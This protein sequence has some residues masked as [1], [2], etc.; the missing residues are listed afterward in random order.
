MPPLIYRFRFALVSAV[1]LALFV[2]G[3]VSGSAGSPLLLGRQNSAGTATTSLNTN[4]SSSAVLFVTQEGTGTA[5]RG[6]AEIGTAGFFTSAGGSAISGVVANPATY[7]FF[8]AN[9]AK[10]KGDGA[11]LRASA[12]A[13]PALVATSDG[14]TPLVLRG[15]ENAPPMT[16]TSSQRVDQLNADATDGWS[17]GCPEG[18]VWSQ[19]L[20]FEGQARAAE[21][22]WDAADACQALGD[23]AG[24]R[25]R[26]ATVQQLR[27]IRGLD[28]IDLDSAGEHTDSIQADGEDLRT[29]VVT[30]EGAVAA[31]P[32]IEAHSFRCIAPP[33][34]VDPTSVSGEEADRYIPPVPVVGTAERDGSSG[35]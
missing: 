35:E 24:W 20:C 22:A 10:E 12:K 3:L 6:V 29:L 30:D 28:D 17:I 19:G 4:N 16:V 2:G 21:S 27:A 13:N 9:E 34:A 23:E 14:S 7:G 33:L 11:A 18:T 15:P 5:I 26:L 31:V 32:A 25:Y 8:A 1:S